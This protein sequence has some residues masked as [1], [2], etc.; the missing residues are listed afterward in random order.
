MNLNKKIM[1]Y[2]VLVDLE[3]YNFGFS[4]FSICGHLTN[5][6]FKLWELET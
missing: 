5:L 1:N 4:C 2:E 3:I 6:N